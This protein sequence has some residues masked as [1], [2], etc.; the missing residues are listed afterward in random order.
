MFRVTGTAKFGRQRFRDDVHRYEKH[1]GEDA[2][3]DSNSLIKRGLPA[4]GIQRDKGGEH[5][6]GGSDEPITDENGRKKFLRIASQQQRH[7]C[8]FVSVLRQRPKTVSLTEKKPI[9]AVE[10]IADNPINP[11]RMRMSIDVMF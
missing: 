10:I 8:P 1:K 5:W 7:G 6:N 11:K 3:H 2:H 4:I 9:S